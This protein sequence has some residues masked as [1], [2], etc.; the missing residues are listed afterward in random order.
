[1]KVHCKCEG[2]VEGELSKE[3]CVELK[4]NN[5]CACCLVSSWYALLYD[6]R[7]SVCPVKEWRENIQCIQYN[8]LVEDINK[9]AYVDKP[10]IHYVQ[11]EGSI[12]N[13]QN[14]RTA[15]IFTVLDNVIDHLNKVVIFA[16]SEG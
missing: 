7:C 3:E 1:M 14:E 13:V 5:C 12:A 11:R 8:K 6:S 4:I 16:N 15:E 9:F 10:F 2:G